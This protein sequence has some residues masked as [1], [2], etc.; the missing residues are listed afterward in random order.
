M[1]LF[2]AACGVSIL[3]SGLAGGCAAA[4]L[5]GEAPDAIAGALT[6]GWALVLARTPRPA[7]F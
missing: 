1:S 2:E 5:G 4:A 3:L 7:G 6:L